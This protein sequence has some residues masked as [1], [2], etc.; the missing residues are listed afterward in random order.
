M[1]LTSKLRCMLG[2]FQVLMV[3]CIKYMRFDNFF[4]YLVV[5]HRL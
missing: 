2:V 3:W 1:H 5:Y 4:L